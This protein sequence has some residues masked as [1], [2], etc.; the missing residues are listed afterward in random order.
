MKSRQFA[1]FILSYSFPPC[2][3][4]AEKNSV[5]LVKNWNIAATMWISK[6]KKEYTV[7]YEMVKMIHDTIIKKM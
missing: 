1:Y 7:Y 5:Y 4:S 2:I 6:F 3:V